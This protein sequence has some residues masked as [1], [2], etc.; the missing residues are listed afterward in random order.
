M[1]ALSMKSYVIITIGALLIT[2]LAVIECLGAIGFAS[3]GRR[4]ASLACRPAWP[5]AL[6]A[7]FL[8]IGH[9]P[10]GFPTQEDVAPDIFTF[11]LWWGLLHFARRWWTR[12]ETA[13]R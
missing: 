10:N 12:S 9:G 13:G 2:G 7:A 11:F 6:V 5:G 3:P 4:L 1:A 8:G